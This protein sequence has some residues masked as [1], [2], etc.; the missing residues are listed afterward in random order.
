MLS[1]DRNYS[2]QQRPE[3]GRSYLV[4]KDLDRMGLS[5]AAHS[6]P[7]TDA[8]NGLGVKLMPTADAAPRRAESSL[9]PRTKAVIMQNANSPAVLRRSSRVPVNVP[10]LVTSLEPGTRFSE[11]CET[12]VVNA[13]GC[14]MRS[15]VKLD[16]GVLLH[17]HSKEGRE[18]TAKVIACQPLEADRTSWR[19][20][21]RLDRPENFWGLTTCPADWAQL[22]APAAPTKSKLP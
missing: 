8:G 16:A 21:A 20:A 10:V 3:F 11:V 4:T 17:F 9:T 13:H 6:T 18:T 22:P 15:P 5:A 14:A 2:V 19:L 1:S 12:L 7:E